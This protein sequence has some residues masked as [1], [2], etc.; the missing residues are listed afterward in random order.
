VKPALSN[1]V[2]LC[3]YVNEVLTYDWNTPGRLTRLRRH[4]RALRLAWKHLWQRRFD[5]AVLPRWGPDNYH[6]AFLAYFSS[7]PWRL[8]YSESVSEE[9]Q[10]LNPGFDRL[11]THVLRDN[12][13]KHQV[14][15]NLD[16]VRS[17]GGAIQEK[18]LEL[19][20]SPKDEAC[21][22]KA[23]RD[24]GVNCD[25]HLI[26]FGLGATQAK[27]RW[28]PASFTELAKRINREIHSRI[29]LV[30]GSEDMNLCEEMQRELRV[31]VI[32]VVGRTTLR[33]TASMLKCCH[34]Y[35]G[36][37]SG[38]MHLAAAAGLPV[39]EISCHPRNGS[40]AHGNSPLRFGPW[41][42]PHKILQPEK[43][44]GSCTEACE[45]H[46]VHCILDVTVEQVKEAVDTLLRE[47][48]AA[49]PFGRRVSR[50]G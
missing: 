5:L 33:E 8:G 34:L 20:L 26:A 1:L 4:G 36:N 45:A 43:G 9:K 37:D 47:Q 48:G 24:H 16:V 15:H 42:V 50:G 25:E 2:E 44:M 19:W 49:A 3:P 30:G 7:A 35:V 39:V 29:L 38:P 11:L 41:G 46:E 27:K 28:P 31:A 21:A 12:T 23:L 10:R 40:P 14:E 6:G 17:L 22:E 18:Q 13:E 32:N